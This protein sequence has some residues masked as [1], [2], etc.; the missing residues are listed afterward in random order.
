[1]AAPRP[2]TPPPFADPS[3]GLPDELPPDLLDSACFNAEA[4]RLEAGARD[5][6][7]EDWISFDGEPKTGDPPS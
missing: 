4:E 2:D 5:E 1:M 3:C 6:S 7:S